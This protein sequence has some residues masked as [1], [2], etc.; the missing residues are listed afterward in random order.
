[1][2]DELETCLHFVEVLIGEMNERRRGFHKICRCG[3]HVVMQ[4]SKTS[5]KPWRLFHACPY[6]RDGVSSID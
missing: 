5:K 6:R 3:E 1:M 2:E 4:T